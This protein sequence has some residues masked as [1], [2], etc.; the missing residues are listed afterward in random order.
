MSDEQ[1]GTPEPTDPEPEEASSAA[2]TPE[3]PA[4][5]AA[6]AA[7]LPGPPPVRFWDK[8]SRRTLLIVT[9]VLAVWAIT[10][11]AF[12]FTGHHRGRFGLNRGVIIGRRFDGMFGN[13]N[14]MGGGGMMNGGGGRW[15]ACPNGVIPPQGANAS[16][17]PVP[18]ASP[19]TTPG[20]GAAYCWINAPGGWS[21]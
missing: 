3:V 14:R 1:T 19:V 6:A 15:I 7:P 10:A 2:G 16:N 18:S 4:A 21:G 20:Q 13:G 9:A 12:A 8:P 5:S 17:A 11:T